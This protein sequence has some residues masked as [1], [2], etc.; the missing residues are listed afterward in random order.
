[1]RASAPAAPRA[2]PICRTEGFSRFAFFDRSTRADLVSARVIFLRFSP[3]WLSAP[4]SS[5]LAA[6][7]P[8]AHSPLSTLELNPTLTSLDVLGFLGA[9]AFDRKAFDLLH[10]LGC[11]SSSLGNHVRLLIERSV[12]SRPVPEPSKSKSL[13]C[14]ELQNRRRRRSRIETQLVSG[15]NKS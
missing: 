6:A 12:A 7:Y 3:S 13:S 11:L 5:M 2:K 10:S 15:G 8:A 9:R 1:M 4:S 14:S